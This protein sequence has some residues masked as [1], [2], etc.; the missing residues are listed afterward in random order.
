MTILAFRKPSART[1]PQ[2]DRAAVPVNV[3]SIHRGTARDMFNEALIRVL[4]NAWRN[5]FVAH[6]RQ[7]ERMYWGAYGEAVRNRSPGQVARMER[8]RGLR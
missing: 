6:D 3:T 7:A 1:Y 4:G 8:E 5:A 2:H